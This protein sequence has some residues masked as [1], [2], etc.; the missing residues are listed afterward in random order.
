MCAANMGIIED[1]NVAILQ[2]AVFGS[3]LDHGLDRKRHHTN[4]YWQSRFALH[5]SVA[6]D[7]MIKPMAGIMRL[8]D[9]GIKGRT[10]EGCVHF[11]CNLFHPAR[12]H[13]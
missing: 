13:R 8:G 12:K 11:I 1:V 2:I 4:E 9:D 6:R 7:R 5:Q 10:K 3:F